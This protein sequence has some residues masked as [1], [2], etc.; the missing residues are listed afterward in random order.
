MKIIAALLLAVLLAGFTYSINIAPISHPPPWDG[1]VWN[2]P[3]GIPSTV[4]QLLL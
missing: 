3:T 1:T 2:N 4:T